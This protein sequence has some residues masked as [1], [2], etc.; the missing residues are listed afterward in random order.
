M[1]IGLIILF[2]SIAVALVIYHFLTIAPQ[3]PPWG[4]ERQAPDETNKG[5]AA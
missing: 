2:G 3:D 1:I 4:D 5:D